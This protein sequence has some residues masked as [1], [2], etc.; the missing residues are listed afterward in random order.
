VIKNQADEIEK[1]KEQTTPLEIKIVSEGAVTPAP[2]TGNGSPR[3][4]LFPA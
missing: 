1:F 3:P 4:E 2:P